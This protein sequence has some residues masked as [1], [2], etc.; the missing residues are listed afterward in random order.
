MSLSKI[1]FGSLLSYT[2]RG[3]LEI[4]A[5]SRNMRSILKNDWFVNSASGKI[6]M[7]DYVAELVKKNLKN[8]SFAEFFDKKPVLIPCPPSGLLKEDSLWVPQRIAKAMVRRGL[9]K[10]VA[11][12][13]VRVTPLRKS[14]TS[15]PE[16]RPRPSE[17]Y[18]SVKV[19]RTLSNPD[20]ILIIDDIVTRGHTIIGVANRLIETYP[21][22]RIRAFAAMRTVSKPENFVKILEPCVGTIRLE[23]D[24]AFR[25]ELILR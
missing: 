21:N 19:E 8:P 14:S 2:P 1:V 11:E 4:H 3:I 23:G 20:E 9:G 15:S 18:N 24:Q 7:S 12:C 22:A 10:S 17:H 5:K 25:N 6:Q 13:V 16:N